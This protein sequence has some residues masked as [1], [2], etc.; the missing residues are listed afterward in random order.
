MHQQPDPWRW[1]R[2]P[3]VATELGIG[4]RSL[5]LWCHGG[6]GYRPALSHQKRGRF[7]MVQPAAAFD[8]L[9]KHAHS[10]SSRLKQ[11]AGYIADSSPTTMPLISSVD[12]EALARDP[13]LIESLGTERAR[14]IIGAFSELRRRENDREKRAEL[15]TPDQFV[16]DFHAIGAVFCEH[17]EEIGARRLAAKLMTMLR[18]QFGVDL[19][20][21]AGAASV[22]EHAIREDHNTSLAEFR[23]EMDERSRGVRMIEGLES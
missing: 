12:L 2:L 22:L 8:H 6:E 16:K 1:E 23:K 13:K 4:I 11:P 7:I 15:L 20:T 17:V 21:H 18:Q 9:T 3:V 19:S 5:Q 14:V 10:M